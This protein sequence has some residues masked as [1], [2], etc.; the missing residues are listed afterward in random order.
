[1]QPI[2]QMEILNIAV[3]ILVETH[4]ITCTLHSV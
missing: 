4:K 2:T 1:M 3:Q